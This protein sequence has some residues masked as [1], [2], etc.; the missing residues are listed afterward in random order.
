MFSFLISL[1]LAEPIDFRVFSFYDLDADCNEIDARNGQCIELVEFTEYEK[2]DVSG[3]RGHSLSYFSLWEDLSFSYEEGF[4]AESLGEKTLPE[5][6]KQWSAQRVDKK[7]YSVP[8]TEFWYN[9]M[10]KIEDWFSPIK[11]SPK[12]ASSNLVFFHG[13]FA[14]NLGFRNEPFPY[15]VMFADREN[16][17]PFFEQHYPFVPKLMQEISDSPL[18]RYKTPFLIKPADKKQIIFSKKD[19]VIRKGGSLDEILEAS[20]KKAEEEFLFLKDSISTLIVRYAASE[21]TENHIQ[22]LAS[23]TLMSRPPDINRTEETQSGLKINVSAKGQADAPIS[24]RNR[25]FQSHDGFALSLSHIPSNVVTKW[26]AH[27]EQFH[28]PDASQVQ[29][30]LKNARV[31][32]HEEFLQDLVAMDYREVWLKSALLPNKD[33]LTERKKLNVMYL[34]WLLIQYKSSNGKK[35]QTVKIVYDHFTEVLYNSLSKSA[36]TAQTPLDISERTAKIWEKVLAFHGSSTARLEQSTNRISPVS[37]CTKETQDLEK[38]FSEPVVQPITI[39]MILSGP[40]GLKTSNDVLM[41]NLK[42]IDFTMMDHPSYNQPQFSIVAE[43]P[44]KQALYQVQWTV[45]SGW[46]VLWQLRPTE[47]DGFELQAKTAAICEDLYLTTPDL[48]PTLLRASLLDDDFYPTTPISKLTFLKHMDQAEQSTTTK[49]TSLDHI[50]QIMISKVSQLSEQ[51]NLLAFVTEIDRF[52][53]SGI[54]ASGQD[55]PYNRFSYEG[56]WQHGW[57][58]RFSKEEKPMMVAPH[59]KA[60]Q[61]SPST[62][63]QPKWET[64][65]TNDWFTYLGLGTNIVPEYEIAALSDKA[66]CTQEGLCLDNQFALGL[67]TIQWF[68]AITPPPIPLIVPIP[69]GRVGWDVLFEANGN[70]YGLP[71]SSP[72]TYRAH[73]T[74]GVGIRWMN[75]PTFISL[76]SSGANIWGIEQIGKQANTTRTQFGARLLTDIQIF[77]EKTPEQGSLPSAGGE[78]WMGISRGDRKKP[79]QPQTYLTPY[80][81]GFIQPTSTELQYY[82]VFGVRFSY[83][84]A[85]KPE[86]VIAV[87]EAI[88]E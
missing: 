25:F 15:H 21:Y 45:W 16:S 22:I 64:E 46:H 55:S 5:I 47:I 88:P 77:P 54:G 31:E 32:V 4:L 69:K 53:H 61:A 9:D 12:E 74:T 80:I 81:R 33:Y 10:S 65:A 85:G 52:S 78:V 38:A 34:Q 48:V 82:Y 40:K 79:Y 51:N 36:G 1:S 58:Q 18:Y 11:V 28:R 84:F 23:L 8:N 3:R 87:K 62:T 59:K 71:W 75:Y 44:G 14:D 19:I 41:W 43:L 67:E 83:R 39:R 35:L 17:G 49:S 70:F 7:M 2:L 24:V 63:W 29:H 86:T 20:Q 66:S 42:N 68:H 76:W 60:L 73:I 27:L 30:I 6:E 13:R 50:K 26:I 56:F 57:V 37:V 72:N